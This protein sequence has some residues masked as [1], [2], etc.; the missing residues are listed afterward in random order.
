MFNAVAVELGLT[1]RG[2]NQVIKASY[3]DEIKK[4]A[5]KMEIEDIW[6]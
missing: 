4:E 3:F 6:K 5:N 2:K 1:V